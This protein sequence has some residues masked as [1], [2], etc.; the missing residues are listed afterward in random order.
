M[1]VEVIGI[2][3]FNAVDGVGDACHIELSAKGSLCILDGFHIAFDGV[4]IGSHGENDGVVD[5]TGGVELDDA[6]AATRAG[7]GDVLVDKLLND[8]LGL[9][10]LSAR[11]E[12][13]HGYTY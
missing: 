1:V 4:G 7:F 10:L 11:D 9:M 8:F 12:Q 6:D 2:A 5:D 13:Q 3:V